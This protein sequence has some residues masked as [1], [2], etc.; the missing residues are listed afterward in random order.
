MCRFIKVYWRGSPCF[1]LLVLH[2]L[3][4]TGIGLASYTYYLEKI[5]GRIDNYPSLQIAI[6][7][8]Q[9]PDNATLRDVVLVVR[10]D[11]VLHRD[12]NHGLANEVVTY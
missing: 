3:A 9:L 2:F 7:Y 1:K 11:E 4:G 5:N 10:E 6:S 12:V 8:W